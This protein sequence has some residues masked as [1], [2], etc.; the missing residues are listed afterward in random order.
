M[1]IFLL[2]EIINIKNMILKKNIFFFHKLIIKKK[3]KM[4]NIVEKTYSALQGSLLYIIMLLTFQ[5]KSFREKV[6]LKTKRDLK[7][8]INNFSEGEKLLNS[9]FEE[10][11]E[12]FTDEEIQ[13]IIM[14]N[15]F[16]MDQC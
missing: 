14:K 2:K 3:M 12:I 16:T 10:E 5:F 7:D 6:L 8:K 4:N 1:V 13:N 15:S 11:Q 9:V